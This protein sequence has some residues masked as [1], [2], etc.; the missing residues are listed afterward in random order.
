MTAIH[1]GTPNTGGTC[2]NS[3]CWC[4]G[5]YVWNTYQP[6]PEVKVTVTV[7]GEIR[8][9]PAQEPRVESG[10]IQFGTDWPGVFIRGDSAAWA[11]MLLKTLLESGKVDDLIIRWELV[12]LQKLLSNCVIGLCRGMVV[13]DEQ[14]DLPQ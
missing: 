9:L 10:T 3:E 2:D 13:M 6:K 5:H 14:K 8:E 4:H 12:N 11:A 7:S 1:Y